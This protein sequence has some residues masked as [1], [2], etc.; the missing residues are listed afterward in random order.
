[1]S[2]DL[3]LASGLQ[4][5]KTLPRLLQRSHRWAD[6]ARSIL[7]NPLAI[8]EQLSRHCFHGKTFV[9][10]KGFRLVKKISQNIHATLSW[11][12]CQ[13]VKANLPIEWHKVKWHFCHYENS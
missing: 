8:A 4:I 13:I 7:S 12:L 10:S 3:G 6:L 9:R 2:G 11:H 1:M 5:V